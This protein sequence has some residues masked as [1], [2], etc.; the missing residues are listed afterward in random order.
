[1][2]PSAV[3][4]VP[5][6]PVSRMDFIQFFHQPVAGYFGYDG[7]TSDGITPNVSFNYGFLRLY[8]HASSQIPDFSFK[9]FYMLEYQYTIVAIL[10]IH[11]K[12][13]YILLVNDSSKVSFLFYLR[14]G[15]QP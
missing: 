15:E 1:M 13:Y 14:I 5:Y 3:T 2:F 11:Q 7:G 8:P 12:T 9:L 4:F 6:Q 10:L